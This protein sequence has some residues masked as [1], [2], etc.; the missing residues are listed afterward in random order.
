MNQQGCIPVIAFNWGGNEKSRWKWTYQY[1]SVQVFSP[2][3]KK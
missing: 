1:F 2:Y 3:V